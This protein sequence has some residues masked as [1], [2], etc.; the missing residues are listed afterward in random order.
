LKPELICIKE[1]LQNVNTVEEWIDYIATAVS[2]DYQVHEDEDLLSTL[3]DALANLYTL[4]EE[5]ESKEIRDEFKIK[6]IVKTAKDGKK[7]KTVNI[8]LR[9]DLNML[10]TEEEINLQNEEDQLNQRVR[11]LG[12]NN[13]NTHNGYNNGHEIPFETNLNM[14]KL[15]RYDTVESLAKIENEKISIMIQNRTNTKITINENSL[16]G[17]MVECEVLEEIKSKKGM[18]RFA[19]E[20]TKIISVNAIEDQMENEKWKPSEKLKFENKNLTNDQIE[21]LKQLVDRFPEVFAKNDED[22][23]NVD[24]QFGQHDIE[25][26]FGKTD[27]TAR[28]HDSVCKRENCQRTSRQ[29]VENGSNLF[30]R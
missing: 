4:N 20:N 10:I 6:K 25:T 27:K 26:D 30:N 23:G 9:D 21:K 5:A 18:I 8:D 15:G 13:A 3:R 24:K 22:I 19:N 16:L 28:I 14:K 1:E 11:N 12:L 17:K 2:L 7:K 29:I